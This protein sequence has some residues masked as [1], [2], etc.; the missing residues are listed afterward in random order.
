MSDSAAEPSQGRV[1]SWFDRTYRDEGF[2]YL[3]PY[4]AYPNFVQ[5][6]GVP[7]GGRVLDVACGPGHLL[8]AAQGWGLRAH[9][10]DLSR[11]ALRLGRRYVPSAR[12]V[13]A[14]AQ[15]L[16]FADGSFDGVTCV[17]AI[18]R[19]LDRGAALDEI[20]R[21]SGPQARFCFMV[22]NAS[23]L[24]WRI[25]RQ[26]CGKRNQEGHQ[27]ALDLDQWRTLFDDHG[28][29]VERVVPDQWPRRRIGWWFG[30]RRE[31]LPGAE[32]PLARAILPL[33]WANEFIFVLRKSR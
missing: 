18:E 14:N 3:R 33:R 28:F 15:R 31:P 13:F 32:S 27:D 23:T 16:P 22:R 11:E 9:G 29:A 25:W 10:V 8:R 20:R 6:L 30:G 19:F 4:A 7:T 1:A 12:T 21:V 2:R 17:G 5:L 24:S 26:W